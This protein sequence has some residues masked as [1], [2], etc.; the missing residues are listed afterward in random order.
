MKGLNR[1]NFTKNK[2]K[3][4]YVLVVFWHDYGVFGKVVIGQGWGF[5]FGGSQPIGAV[6]VLPL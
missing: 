3:N 1:K 5:G 4:I 2:C 6:I